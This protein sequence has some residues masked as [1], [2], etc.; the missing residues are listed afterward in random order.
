M[1][2]N[3]TDTYI[4]FLVTYKRSLVNLITPAI[5]ALT[6]RYAYLWTNFKEKNVQKTLT[7]RKF[8][9]EIANLE[10]IAALFNVASH[11]WS[12]NKCGYRKTITVTGIYKETHG[13]FPHVLIIHRNI[14][15][16]FRKKK[17]PMNS[18]S[19]LI[20]PRKFPPHE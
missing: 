9:I 6:Q 11:S 13:R 15:P 16:L 2:T 7:I 10:G 14:S 8:K 5:V 19:R 18:H 3:V 1:N 12:Y 17:S 20:L 4:R